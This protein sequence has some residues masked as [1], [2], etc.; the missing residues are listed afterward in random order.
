MPVPPPAGLVIPPSTRHG[1]GL[2]WRAC[3]APIGRKTARRD[4]G[5]I[6][7]PAQQRP[8]LG[9]GWGTTIP[10][11]PRLAA[12]FGGHWGGHSHGHYAYQQ[13]LFSQTELAFEVSRAA[14]R[15]EEH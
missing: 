12:A 15:S 11:L 14:S 6:D 4:G 8:A 5:G 10:V 7:R 13:L 1:N 3:C 9:T 2:A